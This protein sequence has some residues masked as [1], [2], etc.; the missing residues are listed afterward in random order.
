M[1]HHLTNKIILRSTGGGERTQ[2]L[3]ISQSSKE[4]KKETSS[5]DD[6]RGGGKGEKRS[7]QRDW[8]LEVRWEIW[9]I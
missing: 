5:R 3:P 7:G 6:G 4:E 8:E 1:E 9:S 2:A